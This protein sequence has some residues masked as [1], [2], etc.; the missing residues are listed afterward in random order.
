MNEMEARVFTVDDD[1]SVRK[2]LL[3]LFRSAGLEAE[4]F[5]SASEFLAREPCDQP[6]C[7]VLDMSMPVLTGP[8][9]Q[10]ELKDARNEIP[11]IFL[12][13]HGDVPTTVRAMRGG[14]VDVL[15]KPVSD[16]DLLRVVR[17]AVARDSAA[18]ADRQ[19]VDT[20]RRRLQQLTPSERK[21]LSLVITGMLNKQ[22]AW[23]L[24]TTERTVKAHRG[25]VMRKMQV[26]SVADLVRMAERLDVEPAR[27]GSHARP[28]AAAVRCP[29][30]QGILTSAIA[31]AVYRAD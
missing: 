15:T 23:E 22:I 2:A 7:L 14:A 13:G 28:D 12:T 4:G 3:R 19:E 17:A 16:D 27:A 31:S 5:A 9:L 25:R 11:V 24:G 30:G 20:L 21:V 1:Q 26:A 29:P 8:E 10:Q 18:R 6:S